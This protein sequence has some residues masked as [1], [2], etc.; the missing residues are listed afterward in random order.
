VKREKRE[1]QKIEASTHHE[2]A[3]AQKRTIDHLLQKPTTQV[4]QRSYRVATL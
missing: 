2:R 3:T 1:Y 4:E